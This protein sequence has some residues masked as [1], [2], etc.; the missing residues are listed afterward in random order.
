MNSPFLF[1][2]KTVNYIIG[3]GALEQA[4]KLF[5]QYPSVFILMDENVEKYCLEVLMNK[6]PDIKVRGYIKIPS[7]ESSKSIE[8]AVHIW[9]SLTNMDASRDSLLINLGGG[10]VSDIGGFCA[11]TFK[12]GLPF[13]NIPTTLLAQVDASIGGKTGIDF[14]SFKNQVGL[15]VDPKAVVIDP[16]FLKTLEYKYWQ[17]GFA[18]VT[19]H[20]L[21]M[22]KELWKLLGNRKFTEIEEW[23]NI[24]M[25]SAKDKIDIVRYDKTENGIRKILNFGHT[26]GHAI[27][28]F[29]LKSGYPITHGQAV[30]AGMICE[31]W[32]S[33]R[34][35]ELECDNVEEIIK[36]V[37]LNFERLQFTENDIPKMMSLMRQDKK[38]IDG[39]IKFSLLRKLGKAVHDI[40][41]ISSELIRDSLPFY[42]NNKKCN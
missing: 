17:S 8:H 23:N 11:S 41:N 21:I 32:I 10:V 14:L 42:I 5:S 34:M 35:V 18:E 29:Y 13:I 4:A 1:D 31:T 33:S 20:A 6:L 27:E 30:A 36:R 19:K 38:I 12:R 7:G 37:D 40:G 39:D 9:E 16:V 2:T 26:V 28:T 25:R 3:D 24:I 15:F 22:D